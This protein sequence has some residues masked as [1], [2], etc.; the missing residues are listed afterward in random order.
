M[1]KVLVWCVALAWLLPLTLK[2]QE[3]TGDTTSSV[4]WEQ[5]GLEDGRSGL[6]FKTIAAGTGGCV[7]GSVGGLVFSPL[8]TGGLG[9]SLGCLGGWGLGSI[10]QR[11]PSPPISKSLFYQEAYSR[12][13]KKGK[14]QSNTIALLVGAGTTVLAIVGT[15]LVWSQLQPY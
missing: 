10:T 4:Y 11:E 6:T 2:A 12:G 9:G 13:Y 3:S 1:K 7:L 8:I 5:R 15:A 14:A